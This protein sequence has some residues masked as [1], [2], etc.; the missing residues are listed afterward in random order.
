[1]V[2]EARVYFQEGL[3]FST[4]GLDRQLDKIIAGS[5]RFRMFER[6]GKSILGGTLLYFFQ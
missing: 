2:E 3:S 6:Q 4:Q 1:M 5:G